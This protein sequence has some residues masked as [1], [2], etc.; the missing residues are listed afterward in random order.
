MLYFI[1]SGWFYMDYYV[2]DLLQVSDEQGYIRLNEL[3]YSTLNLTPDTWNMLYKEDSKIGNYKIIVKK[4]LNPY[5]VKEI[6]TGKKIP[7]LQ[8]YTYRECKD[9]MLLH[10][11][12]YPFI[13]V[14]TFVRKLYTEENKDVKISG[15]KRIRDENVI[16]QYKKRHSDE[17][18]WENEL[19]L[20]FLNGKKK[21]LN[22]QKSENK[23]HNSK[24]LE[25]KNK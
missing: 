14:H 2:C 23:K 5:I 24:K 10:Y 11:T 17:K 7:L 25:Y 18:S 20:Y 13:R 15:L 9:S 12:V 8:N 19:N 1:N 21:M 22:K 4:T 16:I 3:S 6:I